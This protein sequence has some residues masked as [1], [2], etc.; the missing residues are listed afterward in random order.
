MLYNKCHLVTQKQ[1]QKLSGLQPR[2]YHSALHSVEKML[3]LSTHVSL[4]EL[5]VRFGCLEAEQL[6]SEILQKYVCGVTLCTKCCALI[7][8]GIGSP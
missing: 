8:G 5:A 1:V 7:V 3:D 6:A 4:R 2:P